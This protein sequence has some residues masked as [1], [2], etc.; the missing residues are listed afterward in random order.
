MV[1]SLGSVSV[2]RMFF[3]TIL[4]HLTQEYLKGFNTVAENRLGW[5]YGHDPIA[6][7][8]SKPLGYS[9]VPDITH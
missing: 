9:D 5:V 1:T 4:N 2:I 8:N 3:V 6:H 7:M